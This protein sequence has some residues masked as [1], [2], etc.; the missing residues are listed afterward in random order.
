MKVGEV[1]T[2]KTQKPYEAYQIRLEGS[3]KVY[4]RCDDFNDTPGDFLIDEDFSEVYE[5]IDC[6]S[7]DNWHVDQ[8]TLKLI[9]SCIKFW[10]VDVKSTKSVNGVDVAFDYINTYYTEELA[11]K[12]AVELTKD[13][14]TLQVTVHKWLLTTKGNQFI[15]YDYSGFNYINYSHREMLNSKKEKSNE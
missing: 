12:A 5:V 2:V 6:E 7:S 4:Q 9:D 10:L 13:S 3:D 8:F 11:N 1:I 14:D 15:D